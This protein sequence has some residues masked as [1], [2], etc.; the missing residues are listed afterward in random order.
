[1]KYFFIMENHGMQ[2]L[3]LHRIYLHKTVL[4]KFPLELVWI[5]QYIYGM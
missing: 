1:M 3:H 2:N 5:L 4:Q